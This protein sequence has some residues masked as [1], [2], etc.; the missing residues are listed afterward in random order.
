MSVS[1]TTISGPLCRCSIHGGLVSLLI[2]R[3]FKAPSYSDP[4]GNLAG[5]KAQACFFATSSCE[6]WTW[7]HFIHLNVWNCCGPILCAGME[8]WLVDYGWLSRVFV[9]LDKVKSWSAIWI[10]YFSLKTEFSVLNDLQLH[11][12]DF[13]ILT[14]C[15]INVAVIHQAKNLLPQL[16]I[17]AL[18]FSGRNFSWPRKLKGQLVIRLLGGYGIGHVRGVNFLDLGWIIRA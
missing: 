5:L 7:A 2:W 18:L 4:P 8:T 12:N 15:W 6:E 10:S 16:C 3:R 14:A 17:S 11:N 13:Q 9:C 1:E